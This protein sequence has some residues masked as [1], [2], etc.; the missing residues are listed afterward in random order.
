M[1]DIAMLAK[2]RL[3]ATFVAVLLFIGTASL[4][5]RSYFYYDAIGYGFKQNVVDGASYFGVV[6]FEIQKSYPRQLVKP[7]GLSWNRFPSRRLGPVRRGVL[8][9]MFAFGWSN[10]V[11]T[12]PTG[13]GFPG[14]MMHIRSVSIPMWTLLVLW[15]PL[16][17]YEFFRGRRKVRWGLRKDVQWTNFRLRRRVTRFAVF[18]AAGAIAGALAAWLDIE[19]HLWRAQ[20]GWMPALVTLVAAV[21]IPII[22]GRRRIRWYS[23]LL[24]MFLE[25][26][27]CVSFFAATIQWV[28]RYF[29]GY[30]LYEPVLTPLA[31]GV[32]LICFVWGAIL[33][34][35]FQARREPIK[36]GPYCPE[37]GYCLIGSPRQ[38]CP[39]CGRAFTLEELGVAPEALVPPGGGFKTG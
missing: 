19:F 11:F 4:W 29:G 16:P 5:V 18:S 39:E 1:I 21:S 30:R 17:L 32:G 12:Y 34:L 10:Q 24:W 25:I 2:W 3:A 22:L 37:C 9:S 8:D 20:L 27:G 14:T 36:P 31:L 6:G 13:S 33:L 23:A 35:F 7:P 15:A 26:A 38:I 28:W